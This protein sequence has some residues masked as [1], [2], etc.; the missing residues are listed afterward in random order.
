MVTSTSAIDWLEPQTHDLALRDFRFHTGEVMPRLRMRVTALGNPEGAPVL[1]LHGTGSEGRTLLNDDFAGALFGP[2]QALD[3]ARHRIVLPDAIGHGGSAKP[4]DGLRAAFPAYDYDDIVDAHHRLLIEVLGI[5]RLRLVLGVSMG[6][7]LTWT[8]GV[9]YPS[10][11]DAL[12]PLA[13][14]P[15]PMSGRNWLLRRLVIDAIRN[16]PDWRD[17]HYDM[18]PRSARA[19]REFFDLATNGGTLALQKAAPTRG[20][21][22]R[23]LAARREATVP[24]DANDLLYQFQAARS[25]D[26]SA[27]LHRIRAPVLAINSDDDERN[28][29]ETMI[30]ANAMARLPNARLHVVRGS[31]GTRGH[32]TV[33]LA[34]LWAAELDSFLASALPIRA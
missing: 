31:D 25:Y 23:W 28:P 32:G 5:E 34:G 14:L 29:P 22:D 6:G 21:A 4:S 13:S 3:A 7:M 33:G 27:Q 8:W 26:P 19:A 10:F 2:G 16:D 9:R 15:A 24:F 20:E 30:A 17:G 1:V 11:M 12:V 18:Q